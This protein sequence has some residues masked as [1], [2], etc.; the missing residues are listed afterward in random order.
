MSASAMVD[1]RGFLRLAGCAG[2]AGTLPLVSPAI[3]LASLDRRLEAYAKDHSWSDPARSTATTLDSS[4]REALAALGYLTGGGAA[5]RGSPFPSRE[6]LAGMVNPVENALTLRYVNQAGEALRYDRYERSV[7]MAR[8]GLEL[9]PDNTRLREILGR[10]QIGLGNWDKAIAELERAAELSPSDA[11]P[12]KLLGRV[13]FTVGR[14]GQ[15][16]DAD[17]ADAHLRLPRRIETQAQQIALTRD[18]HTIH[19]RLAVA[20]CVKPCRRL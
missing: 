16:D 14:F 9:D 18:G 6:E 19:V 20:G 12:H 8:R 10:A 5:E 4:V 17:R 13:Y 2:L 1:R 3:G 7:R 15:F 11:I